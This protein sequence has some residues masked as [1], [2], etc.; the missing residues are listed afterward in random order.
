MDIMGFISKRHLKKRIAKIE[1]LK[2]RLVES[3]NCL[4]QAADSYAKALNIEPENKIAK[5][6]LP[7]CLRDI[8]KTVRYI[9][10]AD[11]RLKLLK[12]GKLDT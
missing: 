3:N 12:A 2:K 5:R 7:K 11:R 1:G 9:G 4:K 6:E 10:D 8:E